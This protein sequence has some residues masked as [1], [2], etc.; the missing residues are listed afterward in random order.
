MLRWPTKRHQNGV[1][2]FNLI[3][4]RMLGNSSDDGRWDIVQIVGGV[5]IMNKNNLETAS[6]GA[7]NRCAD[8]HLGQ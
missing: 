4:Q 3:T 8:T 1:C 2:K 6:E 5:S 7:P